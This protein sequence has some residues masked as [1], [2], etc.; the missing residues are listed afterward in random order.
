[1]HRRAF[2]CGPLAGLAGLA[3]VFA[4]VAPAAA[5]SGGPP[6][7]RSSQP[8]V[9]SPVD[10]RPRPGEMAPTARPDALGRSARFRLTALGFRV[11]RQ[12][13]DTIDQSDGRGDEVYVRANY[14]EFDRNG[15]QLASDTRRTAL[16][17]QR[18][19][20]QGGSSRSGGLD[21]SGDGGLLSGDSY[22]TAT[23]WADRGRRAAA[24]DLPLPIWEGE[25]ID[26]GNG[27]LVLPSIWEWDGEGATAEEVRWQTATPAA[28]F[29]RRSRIAEL[30]RAWPARQTTPLFAD[31]MPL[32]ITNE[33]TRPIGSSRR[34]TAFPTPNGVISHTVPMQ[35][36][37]LILTYRSATDLLAGPRSYVSR[38]PGATTH[39]VALPAGVFPVAMTDGQDMEGDYTLFVKLERLP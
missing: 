8:P 33:G 28:V 26:G 21:V 18:G 19:T 20:Y 11:E 5:A 25:L 2:I 34:W 12:S 13:Y 9:A 10:M 14:F 30:I 24:D 29:A 38:T 22:P 32:G 4:A 16:I 23:P 35:A 39:V 27:V 6:P 15:H 3:I 17:G 7:E 1:M 37:P 36:D 31:F